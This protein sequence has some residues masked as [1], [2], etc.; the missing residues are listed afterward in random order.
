[1]FAKYTP[2]SDKADWTSST[3]CTWAPTV[4]TTTQASNTRATEN[5]WIVDSCSASYLKVADTDTWTAKSREGIVCDDSGGKCDVT[6]TDKVGTSQEDLCG[7]YEVASGGDACKVSSDCGENGQCLTVNGEKACSCL[8][9]YTGSDCS[10]KDISTCSSLA[11]S[12]SAPKIV[13][14]GVGVFLGVMLVVFIA[15]G[16]IAQ[17]KKSGTSSFALFA[18]LE[19]SGSW[20]SS[21]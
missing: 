21:I 18:L 17:K 4:A 11:S 12:K 2:Y 10:V 16:V 7:T 19:L 8:T 3:I 6:V 14:V 9:C 15:L 20:I 1:M 5:G 13:F